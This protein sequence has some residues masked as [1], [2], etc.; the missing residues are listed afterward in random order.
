[1]RQYGPLLFLFPVAI[2]L[3]AVFDNWIIGS[4]VAAVVVG[5]A[6]VVWQMIRK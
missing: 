6:N 3:G 5:V 2:V 4:V 1:M